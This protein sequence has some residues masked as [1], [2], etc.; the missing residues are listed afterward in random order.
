M[1]EVSARREKSRPGGGTRY[2]ERMLALLTLMLLAPAGEAET[3]TIRLLAVAGEG[4]SADDLAAIEARV[5]EEL[6]LMGATMVRGEPPAAGCLD[7]AP[8]RLGLVEGAAGALALELVRVGPILQVKAR[9]FGPDGAERKWIERDVQIDGVSG[10]ASLL[11]PE[12]AGE[13]RA[14]LSSA[15]PPVTVPADPAPASEPAEEGGSI[16]PWVLAGSGF[17]VLGLG[18]VVSVAGVGVALWQTLTAYTAA[19]PG[20]QKA[21]ALIVAPVGVGAAIAG[22]VVIAVGGAVALG[23]LLVE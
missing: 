2:D 20:D 7:D 10:A 22:V 8:C 5:G 6:T 1:R 11:G 12:M 19:T 17:G 13:I 21:T 4:M 16:L 18:A 14:L 15:A 9:L 3:A 23:A